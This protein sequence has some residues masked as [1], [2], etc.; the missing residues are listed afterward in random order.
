MIKHLQVFVLVLHTRCFL[1]PHHVRQQQ[2]QCALMAY[3]PHLLSPGPE[4]LLYIFLL[5][6]QDCQLPQPPCLPSIRCK[7]PCN[8]T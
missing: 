7:T 3:C 5:L 6:P 1:A 8:G 2:I 4:G